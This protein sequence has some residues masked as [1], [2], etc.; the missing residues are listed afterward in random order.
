MTWTYIDYNREKNFFRM[1]KNYFSV[2]ATFKSESIY[3]WLLN[4]DLHQFNFF[5]GVIE[6]SAHFCN[7]AFEMLHNVLFLSIQ[8]FDVFQR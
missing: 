3:N 8:F 2:I 6:L 7:P 4:R 5:F 1:L